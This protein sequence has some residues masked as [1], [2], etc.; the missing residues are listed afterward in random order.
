MR[1]VENKIQKILH[2]KNNNNSNSNN[3]TANNRYAHVKRDMNVS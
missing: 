1:N 2:E 3:N